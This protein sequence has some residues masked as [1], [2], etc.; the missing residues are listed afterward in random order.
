M[1]PKLGV[2]SLLLPRL[3][4]SLF[5]R[6]GSL[7]MGGVIF[8]FDSPKGRNRF[9]TLISQTRPRVRFQSRIAVCNVAGWMACFPWNDQQKFNANWSWWQVS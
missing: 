2:K 9:P 3:S 4:A 6:W 7:V 1:E 8:C 5:L